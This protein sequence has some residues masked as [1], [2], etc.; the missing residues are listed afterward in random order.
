MP[1]NPSL[2]EFYG[3]T[4]APPPPKKSAPEVAMSLDVGELVEEYD[5]P[6]DVPTMEMDED[7]VNKAIELLEA[8][9][10]EEGVGFLVDEDGRIMCVRSSDAKHLATQGFRAG[11][12]R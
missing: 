6:E 8:K 7:N 10:I 12:L 4:S 2:D 3:D 5:V 11:D 9:G 1:N